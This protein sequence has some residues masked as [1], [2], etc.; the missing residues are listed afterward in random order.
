MGFWVNGRASLTPQAVTN[1]GLKPG[2]NYIVVGKKQDNSIVINQV[3]GLGTFTGYLVPEAAFIAPV[4]RSE[5]KEIIVKVSPTERFDPWLQYEANIMIHYLRDLYPFVPKVLARGDVSVT[6]SASGQSDVSRRAPY[7]VM[8]KLPGERL[9]DIAEKWAMR[10]PTREEVGSLIEIFYEECLIMA[11]VHDAYIIHRDL[12]PANILFDQYHG[13]SIIDFGSANIKGAKITREDCGS[14]GFF[15]PDHALG[16]VKSDDVSIDI[17][18]LGAALLALISSM[19][20]L[21]YHP[22]MPNP[23]EGS[24]STETRQDKYCRAVW[25]Y[26]NKSVKDL[27]KLS[28]IPEEF[29][30]TSLARLL[31]AMVHPRSEMRPQSMLEVAGELRRVSSEFTVHQL[32]G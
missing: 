15:P 4:S 30:S 13:P 16:L 7:F 26:S 23:W 22:S 2:V 25:Q 3:L 6:E 27:I 8:P 32:A 21:M 29:K 11:E 14:P 1:A 17:F 9:C 12:K 10:I 5:I 19:R 31:F 24:E 18:G 28:N 20:P